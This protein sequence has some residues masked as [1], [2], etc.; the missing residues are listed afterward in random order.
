M[1]VTCNWTCITC[2]ET[3]HHMCS[4]NHVKYH[5]KILNGIT[6]LVNLE[7]W[8][9]EEYVLCWGDTLCQHFLWL[10]DYTPWKVLPHVPYKTDTGI[11]SL[12][13]CQLIPH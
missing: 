5:H 6:I 9:E 12:V 8:N 13:L 3:L 1:C 2:H 10:I 11:I 7:P 4:Y